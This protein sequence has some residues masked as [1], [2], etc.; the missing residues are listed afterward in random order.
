MAVATNFRIGAHKRRN[1]EYCRWWLALRP[2]FSAQA[3]MPPTALMAPRGERRGLLILTVGPVMCFYGVIPPA[4]RS[5]FYQLTAPGSR[6]FSAR[7]TLRGGKA[8]RP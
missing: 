6:L 3:R 5:R 2:E 4:R 8:Q 1:W 7:A